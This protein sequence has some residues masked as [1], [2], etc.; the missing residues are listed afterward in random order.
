MKYHKSEM[1]KTGVLFVIF[2]LCAIGALVGVIYSIVDSL[3]WVAVIGLSIGF[4]SLSFV[5]WGCATAFAT[6]KKRYN[7]VKDSDLLKIIATINPYTTDN[8]MLAAFQK[9]RQNKIY[10]D[11]QIFLTDTFLGSGNFA[12]LIDGILDASINL[13]EDDGFIEKIVLSILYYDGEET[14]FE[15]EKPFGLSGYK[16]MREC[17]CNLEI[18][19][20]LIAQKGK[21][22]RKYDCCRL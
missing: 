18:A 6:A 7:A 1:L 10:E 13:C 21:L 2:L 16:E 19:L 9:E 15:Y 8:E 22:F 14:K 20:N 11:E 12:M 17:A 3:D 4:V 5:T